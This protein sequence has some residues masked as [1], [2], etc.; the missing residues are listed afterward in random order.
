MREAETP[1]TGEKTHSW[2][3]LMQFEQRFDADVGVSSSWE[4]PEQRI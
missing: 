2:L 3:N 1:M 4:N